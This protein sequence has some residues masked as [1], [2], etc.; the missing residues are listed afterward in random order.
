MNQIL[1]GHRTGMSMFTEK[2]REKRSGGFSADELK[3]GDTPGHDFRG[4]QYKSGSGG[5][6]VPKVAKPRTDDQLA[7]HLREHGYTG[8]FHS[9]DSKGRLTPATTGTLREMHNEYHRTEGQDHTH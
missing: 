5:S 3:R 2:V 4:N 8:D 1:P 9:F 7:A 6:E